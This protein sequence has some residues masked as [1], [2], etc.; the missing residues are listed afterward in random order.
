MRGV[1]GEHYGDGDVLHLFYRTDRDTKDTVAMRTRARV[2]WPAFA[3]TVIAAR[4]TIG[5]ITAE[6]PIVE[7]GNSSLGF[8]HIAKWGI[9][10][11]R[12]PAGVWRFD[13]D[14]AALPPP[15]GYPQPIID[16]PGTPLRVPPHR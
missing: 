13:G 5:A 1:R 4:Y 2:I 10:A 15:A 7:V 9:V 6:H 14:T 8:R 3:P 16:S 11:R 12:D